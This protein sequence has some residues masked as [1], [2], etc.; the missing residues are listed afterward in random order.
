MFRINYKWLVLLGLIGSMIY[1]QSCEKDDI[2]EEETPKTPFLV[3]RFYDE[4]NRDIPKAVTNLELTAIEFL[5]QDPPIE[6]LKFSGVSEI[7]IPLKV[8]ENMTEFYAVINKDIED[9]E[10][11]DKI[12]FQ[13]NRSDVYISRA[14]GFK[15]YFDFNVLNPFTISEIEAGTGLPGIGSRWLLDHNFIKTNI[16]NDN[17][18]HL[19]LFY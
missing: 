18:I 14:C 5:N 4:E 6:P 1:L 8:T 19:H 12:R 7:R 17:E 3:I 10:N 9:L 16:N 2:C 11:A 13:Y 15:T